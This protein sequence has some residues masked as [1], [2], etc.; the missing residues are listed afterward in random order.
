MKRVRLVIEDAYDSDEYNEHV[1]TEDLSDDITV[2]WTKG[3]LIPKSE[4]LFYQLSVYFTNICKGED[5]K[6]GRPHV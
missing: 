5:I 3:D 4:A 2:K 6:Y 1:I